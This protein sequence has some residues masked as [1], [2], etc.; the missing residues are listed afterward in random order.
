MIALEESLWFCTSLK[1]IVRKVYD[2]LGV[3]GD[4]FKIVK[5]TLYVLNVIELNDRQF[6]LHTP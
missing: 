6:L 1:N 4:M 2:T 5:S 3:G